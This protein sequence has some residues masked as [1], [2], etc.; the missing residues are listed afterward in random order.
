M[1]LG[2]QIDKSDSVP[3][4]RNVPSIGRVI[5]SFI[6]SLIIQWTLP[7]LTP[8]LGCV[9]GEG[10]S[11]SPVWVGVIPSP[12]PTRKEPALKIFL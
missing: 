4:A 6:H 7:G 3:S 8:G 12:T 5:H 10:I 11:Y 9:G 1:H 2:G